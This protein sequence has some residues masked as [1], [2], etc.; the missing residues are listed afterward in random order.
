MELG[1]DRVGLS[2][3]HLLIGQLGC[4]WHTQQYT[5]VESLFFS[6]SQLDATNMTRLKSFRSGCR[7]VLA[8]AAG[9]WRRGSRR[10]NT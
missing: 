9:T 5:M 1:S 4:V 3:F 10:L 7:A 6:A 8:C 2:L